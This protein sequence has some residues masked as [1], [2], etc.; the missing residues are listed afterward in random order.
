MTQSAPETDAK[1]ETDAK[2][3]R[4]SPPAWLSRLRRLRRPVLPHRLR[5]LGGFSARVIALSSAMT[6]AV[7]GLAFA[8]TYVSAQ[9]IIESQSAALVGEELRGLVEEFQNGGVDEL[10][11]AIQERVAN[12]GDAV[13]LLVDAAG[14]PLAGNLATWPQGV[15]TNGA[16]LHVRLTR[17]ADDEEVEAG[18]RAFVVPGNVRLLV[19]RDFIEQRRF[20]A[21]LSRAAALS[22]LGAAVLATLAASLLNRFV[23]GRV[24]AIDA[25]ARAIV[26]GDLS[27]RIPSG[28]GGDA[29]DRLATTLNAMLERIEALVV[30]LRTV[31]DSVAHDLRTPLTRLKSQ[32]ERAATGALSDKARHEALALANDEAD[33]L[34]VSFSALIEIVRAEAGPVRE[35]FETIDLASL[36]EDVYDLHLPFADDLG[37][38]LRFEGGAPVLVEGHPQFLA[39][40]F[41]NLFDNAFKYGDAQSPEGQNRV[42]ARVY[43]RDGCAVAEIADE[44][45][46][47]APG[48]RDTALSR[49]GRL[50][51]ARTNPGSGLGLALAAT[52]ARVHGGG[53]KL[54]D[55]APGLKV[56]VTLPLKTLGRASDADPQ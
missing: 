43:V 30:E 55:N 6:L 44:G 20:A 56:V 14:M 3:S 27:R 13:Y 50:D 53:L 11:G 9:Q 41:S 51:E 26:A 19:G 22:V 15:R 36:V 49:F 10:A 45:R 42:T 33:R 4:T 1:F 40:L 52:I 5:W 28:G 18:A 38:D 24:R 31:T 23:M 34:L 12:A 7:I 21:A 2:P 16:W 32:I 37:F 47:I 39:Q 35:Q 29:F 8:V 17:T 25:T 48:K 46:G 54:E